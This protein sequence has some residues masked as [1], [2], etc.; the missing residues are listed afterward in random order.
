MT[1][2]VSDLSKLQQFVH[3]IRS[4]LL[5]LEILARRAAPRLEPDQ[6]KLMSNIVNRLRFMA[7]EILRDDETPNTQAV[8]SPCAI[9]DRVMAAKWL[10]LDTR[11]GITLECRFG[12]TARDARIAAHA[13]TLERILSNLINNSFEAIGSQ[14]RVIVTLSATPKR[15][16]IVVEDTGGGFSEEKLRTLKTLSEGKLG[17]ALSSTK[18]SRPAL[19]LMH[20][21]REIRDMGGVL[22]FENNSD[23]GAT[24]SIVLPLAR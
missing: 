18:H 13:I 8:Q 14:G 20:A 22:R 9:I 24:V 17:L 3:D 16:L 11:P 6:R 19:G 21:I 5:S 4:P 12:T 1:T 2:H 15:V 7:D 23:V 10:E